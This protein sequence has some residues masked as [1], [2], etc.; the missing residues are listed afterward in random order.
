MKQFL[1]AL[2][3]LSVGLAYPVYA[4]TLEIEVHGMTCAFCVDSLERKFNKMESI[5]KVDVSLKSKKVRLETEE[6]KPSLETIKKAVLDT[7]FTPVHIT[8]LPDE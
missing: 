3:F 8:V 2:F 5:S 6:N 7:G 4:R 1:I